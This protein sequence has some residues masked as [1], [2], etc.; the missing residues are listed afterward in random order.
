MKS[1]I[2]IEMVSGNQKYYLRR[3]TLNW[4]IYTTYLNR[5]KK[6]K[7]YQAAMKMKEMMN[8]PNGRVSILSIKRSK[9]CSMK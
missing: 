6:F 4:F 9:L 8:F 2:I 5:A 1:K 7:N 3:K